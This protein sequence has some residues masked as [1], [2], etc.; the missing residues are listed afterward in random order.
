M[1]HEQIDETLRPRM[2]Y[3]GLADSL[4]ERIFCHE[5]APG[6]AL[7][8]F[9]LASAYG[10]SRTPLR[11]A[12]KVLASEGLVELRA[13]YGCFVAR[14]E[15]GDVSQLFDI[16]DLLEEFAVRQASILRDEVLPGEEFYEDLLFSSGNQYLPDLVSR[17]VAKLR[18][19]LGSYFDSEAIQFSSELQAALSSA[20]TEGK[21]DVALEMLRQ[22]NHVRRVS[23]LKLFVAEGSEAA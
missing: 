10:V 21:V 2:L 15:Y 17:V 13:R 8:E 20:I 1:R 23:G 4:R 19:A 3:E 7:D 6:E 9:R 16:L 12:L 18:L 11:E 5:L 22:H 14:L